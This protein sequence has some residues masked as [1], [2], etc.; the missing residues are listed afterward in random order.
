MKI[1]LYQEHDQEVHDR[2]NQY[3]LQKECSCCYHLLDWKKIIQTAFGLK[4]YYFYAE[5]EQGDICGILPLVLSKSRL[6]GTFLT[7]VPFFNYG[8]ILSDSLEIARLLLSRAVETAEEI[9]ASHIELRHI[10]SYFP[11]LPTKTHKVRM[12]MPL[13][14]N[15]Q[16][17]W[18][19]FKSKLRSQIKKPMNEKLHVK[20]GKQE[21]VDD[22]YRVFS[23][24]MRDLG[25]PVWTKKIFMDTLQNMP[26]CCDICCVYLND[27]AV[28]AGFLLGFKD[29]LEIWTASTIRKYNHLS[30]NMLL[31]WSVIEFA[32]QKGY[33]FFD[34]GRSSPD[35]GTYSFKKQWGAYPE[36][37]HWQYWLS[38]GDEMPC[39]N[40]QNPKYKLMI[41]AWKK[42]PLAIAN[43]IGPIISR[44]IP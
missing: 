30:P 43:R 42:L 20:F 32:C 14:N 41:S 18:D 6:F 12:V 13:K 40:P 15:S 5:K 10:A 4:T 24:N 3:V 39:V 33:K 22:F 19:G 27:R 11:E 36:V 8:G 25:T 29:T 34:F 9:H 23:T 44:N 38:H 31:Y 17:I 35:S 28:G 16:E 1:V 2:W 26:S 21:L 37:L 7:S